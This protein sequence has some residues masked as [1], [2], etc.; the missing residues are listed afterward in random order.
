MPVWQNN[1]EWNSHIIVG[2]C[3]ICKEERDVS[4][5]EMREIYECDMKEFGT[6]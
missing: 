2:E 3:E 5:E 1:R 4:E 6:L